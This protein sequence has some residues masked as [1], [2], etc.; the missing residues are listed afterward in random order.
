[1]KQPQSA[2][3]GPRWTR[4][5]RSGRPRGLLRPPT[6]QHAD[7]SIET[8]HVVLM[9][10]DPLD[11]P[12]ALRIG[13]RTLRKMRQNL[14]CAVGYNVVA[15]PIAAGAFSKWGLTLRPEIAA[16]S[17]SGSSPIVAGNVLMLKRLRLPASGAGVHAAVGQAALPR[18][19]SSAP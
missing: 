16:P 6:K 14:G 15:L 4:H 5:C 10:S 9:R 18:A 7:V 8:I 13:R 12:T 17:M 2:Q 11:I 1:M 3:P 19:G